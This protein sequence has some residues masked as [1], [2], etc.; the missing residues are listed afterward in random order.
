MRNWR[1]SLLTIAV[2]GAY[3]ALIFNIYSLQIKK[4]GYYSARAASQ[5]RAYDFSD[6][7]RGGIYFYDKQGNKIAAAINR[8][9]PVIFAVPKEIED[10]DEAA[11]ALAPILKIDSGKIKSLITKPDDL[12]ELLSEKTTAEQVAKIQSL[13]IKGIYVDSENFRFYPLGSLAAHVLGFVGPSESDSVVKGR[14]GLESLYDEF[15]KNNDLLLTIDRDIQAQAEKVMRSLID[16]YSASGG[17]VIVQEPKTGKILAMGSYQNFD[18]NEY[19]KSPIKNFLNPAVQSIYEPGSVFKVITMAAGIDSGKITPE[20]KFYDSGSL[21]LNGKT[22][23]NWDLKAHGTVTMANVIEQS[24][25]TGAAFAERKTGHD[26]FYNYL[27]KFGFDEPT[28]IGLPGEVS[29]NLKN[30]KSSFRDINFAT[31]AFGQGVAVTPLQLIAAISAIANNG[32]LMEPRILKSESSL[33]VRRV[34]SEE[35]ARKIT[36]MMVSAVD[37]AEIAKISGY[38]VAGKTGTAQIPDFK[39]GGYSD[40]FIHSYAGFAPASDPRFAILIK[41]DK[42]KGVSLAGSTVVP[43]FR[44]LAQFILNYY[45]IPTDKNEL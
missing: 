10:A 2:L 30:L 45:N 21:T 29:G 17:T 37:K 40:E 14:Y 8:D 23:K 42:P 13:N 38:K 15:L 7:R 44:E 12:Y 19:E 39:N 43:A 34:T 16:K 31:A 18:P 36:A 35:A 27:L 24:I 11:N 22:L 32:V 25:N 3:S 4:G 5:H 41:I 33:E 6:P 1:L 28:G 26:I 9:Y 20:T